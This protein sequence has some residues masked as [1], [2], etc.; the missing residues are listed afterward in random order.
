[1]P[2]FIPQFTP[3]DLDEFTKGY[4]DA[5]EWLLSDS[6][7]NGPY[8]EG[9]EPLA[10]DQDRAEGWS[11][12]AVTRAHN[13]CDAFQGENAPDLLLYEEVTGRSMESAG[14]DFW[15]TRNRHGAGFWDRGDHPCLK[16]L[17]D[18]AHAYGTCDT[19]VGDDNLI[20][21]M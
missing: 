11:E 1:M 8:E 13:D 14:I 15:L 4:M 19:Y 2:E 3:G 9:E 21:L 5:A 17:T 20:Y 12:D 16:R 6:T 7:D 18:A 10:S